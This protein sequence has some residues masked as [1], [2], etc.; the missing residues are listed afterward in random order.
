[1]PLTLG[2]RREAARSLAH[3]VPE[4]G[5]RWL[6]LALLAGCAIAPGGC[7]RSPAAAPPPPPPTGFDAA[8]LDSS[9][10]IVS[11][12]EGTPAMQ[13]LTSLSPLLIPAA[14][15]PAA[16]TAFRASACFIAADRSYAGPAPAAPA[17]GRAGFGVAGLIADS[18][19]GHVF[20][21]DTA[22]RAY[23]TGADT[24]GPAGGI[25]FV[26]YGLNAYGLP[27][28]PLARDGWLDLTDQS[29]GA[30]FRLRAQVGGATAG[31]ADYLVSLSGT[32]A[33]DTAQ[34]GGTVTDGT[35][36]LAFRDSTT[37]ATVAGA[38]AV[39]AAISAAVTDS[40]DGFGLVM[41]ASRVNFDPFDFTDSVDITFTGPAQ[42]LRL[43]GTI[44]TYCLLPSTNLTVSLNGA[45][46]ATITNGTSGPSVTLAGSGGQPATTDEAHALLALKDTQQL[47]FG[48]LGGLLAPAKA[49]LP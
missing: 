25:R 39:R 26:L 18:L 30:A 14:A 4:A 49:L 40:A 32:R 11:G 1:M 21:Y 23:R 48:W 9:L 17:A 34:L 15:P 31:V 19:L 13:S 2:P 44:V 24:G 47:L 43:S 35:H 8:A 33:A 6:R 41:A 28:L 38:I 29:A 20:V 10:A 27:A 36:T 37:S 5:S 12:V 42:R 46:Y 16:R 7:D 3:R 45:A 22:A